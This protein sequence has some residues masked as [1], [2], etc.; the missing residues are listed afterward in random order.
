MAGGL[1]LHDLTTGRSY[2]LPRGIGY[3]YQPDVSPDGK[4][5]VF[6]R[7]IGTAME[8][9]LY[10]ME[11][12]SFTS[13]TQ[14]GGVNVEPRWSPD[15]SQLAFVSTMTTGHFLLYKA[16]V[17]GTGLADIECLTPDRQ[18]QEKRYYYSP[19][20]QS[21]N[22]AWSPDG[23]ELY[24]LNNHDL[25]HG[26]GNLVSMDLASKQMRIIQR[27]ETS[28]K[29]RPDFSPDGTRVV[30]SS[31]LGGQWQQLWFLPAGGG[32]PVP[33]TY[34]EYDNINPRWSPDGT[35]IAFISNRTGNTSLWL[36]DAY[37]GRQQE[38]K[39]NE[40]EYHDNLH[41][42]SLEIKDESGNPMAARVSMVASD[43]LAYAPH[44]TWIHADDSYF[45]KISRFEPVYFHTSG[46]CDVFVPAGEITIRV[47]RGPFY[48]I[49][50]HTLDSKTELTHPVV[51]T[52]KRLAFPPN[53]G[54]WHSADLHVHMNYTGNYLNTPDRLIRQM[55]GEGLNI[56]YNLIVNK[57]QRIPDVRYFSTKPDPAS[58]K[59]YMVLHSQEF[60]T[61]FWGHLGLLNLNDH[62]ILPDYSAYPQT[63]V[64]SH[65]PNNTF[66]IDK[67]HEQGALVGYVHPYEIPEI[68]PDQSPRM[69]HS[70]PVDAALG[71]VDY[72]E[73]MGF[74][75]HRATEWVWHKLLNC[76]IRI[77]AGAGTDAMANYASLRGPIGLNRVYVRGKENV[78]HQSF[79][80]EFKAGRSFVTNGPIIGLTVDGASPGDSLH[81]DPKGQTL[82]YS[83]FLRS[84]LPVDHFEIL[85]NGTPIASH[86]LTGDKKSLD[87]TG[88]IKVK[89]P[90]WLLLHTWAD[91]PD[92]DLTDIYAYA[93]TNPVF[94]GADKQKMRSRESAEYLLRWVKRI[95]EFASQL[96]TWRTPEEKERVMNDIA[97]A[98]KFY[99]KQTI[100]SV[101]AR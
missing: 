27:E 22:P 4:K 54:T 85:W 101:T 30:Y 98:K 45:S 83:A 74:S 52:L 21:I 49:V 93:S 55:Q 29:M 31:Y 36:L 12:K 1:W 11:T 33:L 60:H 17:T 62:L 77:A 23:K 89:G 79:A 95:E 10:N 26:S 91:N 64:S 67:A 99:E 9:N 63:G 34:G 38:V 28:W 7:Y 66:I 40:Y 73:V 46:S 19:F 50:T 71:K 76:G 16:K 61:S 96:T 3:D 43:G 59:E 35:Q 2:Q 6:V 92:P 53:F 70:L 42:V 84:H 25:A 20:D 44:E 14:N 24:F 65:F 94:V 8:W 18:T 56:V 5:I 13:L 15:G 81:I 68:F 41:L 78:D 58:T 90:G 87:A 82:T 37:D 72:V 88:K 48:D 97:A 39:P 47:S 69:T 57:E 80:D 86:S 100:Q 51:I 75:D 32:H